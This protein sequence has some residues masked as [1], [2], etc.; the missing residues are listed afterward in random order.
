MSDSAGYTGS[1]VIVQGGRRI[2]V[3]CGFHVIESRHGEMREWRGWYKGAEIGN[4]PEAGE[5]QLE[6]DTGARGTIS[7]TRALTGTG[8]GTFI[9]VSDPA[10][11][12]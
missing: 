7:I 3:Q 4:E 2:E 9:G 8:E 10:A 11:P 6:I 5:A 12:G 1:A